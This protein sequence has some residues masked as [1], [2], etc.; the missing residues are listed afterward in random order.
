MTAAILRYSA[1]AVI[2]LAGFGAVSAQETSGTR[3]ITSDDFA[4]KRPVSKATGPQRPLNRS[5]RTTYRKRTRKTT[6]KRRRSSGQQAP[7]N[8]KTAVRTDLGVTLWRL[9][10]PL[11]SDKGVKLPVRVGAKREEWTPERVGLDTVFKPG[12]KVRFA[13]ESSSAGYLYV[14][15]SEIYSDGSFGDPYLIFP[16]Q[17]VGNRVQPGMLIDIP[18][19]KE[20]LPYFSINPRDPKY[21]GEL[22]TVIIS[23][24]EIPSLNT[25]KNGKIVG[26]EVVEEME[27]GSEVEEFD[28]TDDL[29]SVFTI[30]ESTAACGARTRSG[31]VQQSAANPCGTGT[32][33]LTRDEPLPQTILQ[34][35]ANPGNPGVAVVRLNVEP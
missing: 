19:Q 6:V 28:R 24:I 33:Q 8:A 23:P 30:A 11:A 10:P 14:I 31:V 20:D 34:I 16:T 32:R 13:V 18:D 27:E 17:G 1:I 26:A 15:N 7:V 5:K 9:R 2:I 22:L 29:D 21:A 3:E 4:S 12:D 35:K 25:D